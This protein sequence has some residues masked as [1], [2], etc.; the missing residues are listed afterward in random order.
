[1]RKEVLVAILVGILL[2]SLVAFGIWRANILLGDKKEK[3]VE[4]F[5]TPFEQEISGSQLVITQPEDSTVVSVDK[6]LVRGTASAG[7]T[8][9]ILA[10]SGEY[11]VEV[12]GDG[13]FDQ[14][15]GLEGG[16]NEITVIAYDA[17]GNESK[18]VL[19][20]VYST[21]FGEQ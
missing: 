3:T 7:S 15:V 1:M 9:V 12:K 18:Q 17:S 14:E 21:E 13:S 19:T 11:I 10:Q 4:V 6:V 20:M 5:P 2:G 16:A 8:V